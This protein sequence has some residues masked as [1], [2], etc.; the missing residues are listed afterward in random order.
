MERSST[1][2]GYTGGS[3]TTPNCDPLVMSQVAMST[4]EGQKGLDLD[5]RS[6]CSDALASPGGQG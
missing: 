6:P 1:S 5:C 2:T 3:S 4:P